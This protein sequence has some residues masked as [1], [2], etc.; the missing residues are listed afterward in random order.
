MKRTGSAKWQGAIKEGQGTLVVGEGVWEA[1]YSFASRFEEAE[2]TNPE[3]LIAAAHAGCF[4]LAFSGFLGAAGHDPESL[5]AQADVHVNRSSDGEGFEINRIDLRVRG[6]VPG[7]SAEDFAKQAEVAKE[8][9]P[10]SRALA[11]VGEITLDAQL[12]G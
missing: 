1:P 4:A 10:V 9:C 11:G 3:E 12:E 2:G 7:I 6:R 5:D 8:Q